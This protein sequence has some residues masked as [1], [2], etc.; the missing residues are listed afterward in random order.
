MPQKERQ[1]D[2]WRNLNIYRN[3]ISSGGKLTPRDKFYYGRELMFCGLYT[4]AAAVLEDFLLGDGWSENKSEACLNLATVYAACG[5]EEGAEKAVVRSFLY[6]CPKSRACC[7]LGEKYMKCGNTG[8]A[9]FWYKTAAG[10]TQ[11]LKCGGFGEEDFSGYIP[12]MQL[13]VLYDR[14]GE[15][16]VAEHYNELAGAIKPHDKSYLHNKEYFKKVNGSR[17]D[18]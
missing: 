17:D 1:K 13:C 10:I 4:E 9:I 5:D 14:L 6:G 3:L 16:S 12:F 7:A 2:K 15:H 8:A 11:D 18:K